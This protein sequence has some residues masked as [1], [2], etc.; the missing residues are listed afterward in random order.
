MNYGKKST[1]KKREKLTS[2]SS[3]MGNKAGVT[4]LRVLFLSFAAVC[5][6]IACMGIGAFRAI[7]DNS[8][9]ISDVNIMPIGNATFVYD[10]DGNMLQKLSAPT[11]NRMS[12][13]IDKIPLDMQHAIVAIEDE[14]FY[15]HNGIDV[16]GILR[17]FVNGVSRGFKFNEGASTLTQQLLKNNV[18]TNWTNEGKIERFIRKFQEQY[19]ALQLEASLTAEGMDTKSVILENYLN[20]INLSAGTYGVQAAAQRY[21]GKNSQDLTLSECAVLAAIP[22]NPYAFNPI[23]HPEKNAERRK[24]VLKNMLEQG[25]ITQEE[26]DEALAD[27]V[28]EQ[29]KETDSSQQTAT[30][31]SYFTDELTSQLIN[32]FQT[33]LGYTKVQAQNALYSGGLSIYTTQ[34]PDIQ[35]IMDEEYQNE[36]NFPSNTQLGLDWALTVTKADGTTQNYSK[37]MMR[38]YFRD[39]VDD[40]FDLLFETEEDARACVEQY[41]E[42]ILNDGDSIVAE[43][44]SFS[45]QPQSSMVII[46]Q[47]T[48]YVK[49]IVGGRGKKTASLTL[50]RATDTYRQPGSTFK[51][52]AVYGPAINDLSLTLADTYVDQGITYE[53]TNRPVKNAYSGYRGTMTIRDAIKVSCNTIAIQAFRDLT[54][55]VGYNYLKRM[56]FEEVTDHKVINGQ[57]FDD[58]REPTALGGITTGVSTLELTAAYAA[59]A[60]KG[61]YIKPVFYTKVLDH[62]G[63][64]LLDN[65]PET[66]QVFRDST[67]YLLTSAMESVVNEEGGT[68]GDL[69]LDNMP[70]AGKTGTTSATRDVWFAGFTP[71]YTCA[72]WAGSD[73]NELLVDECKSFHKTLWKKIM[74]RIHSELPSADFEIPSNVQQAT[75]CSESGLLAGLGCSTRTE[76]FESST[77]PTTRCTQHYVPP[78]PEPTPIPTPTEDPL[79]DPGT[80]TVPG[81]P[82]VPNGEAP[83][84]PAPPTDPGNGGDG[85]VTVVPPAGG[86]GTVTPPPSSP[87]GGAETPPTP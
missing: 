60:N 61:T 44:I 22:Q 31:Y 50:N 82:T 74:G 19:L 45:P 57:V 72:V 17:A 5:V 11:A 51:P 64:I 75:I 56:G 7:I 29:I 20:T 55:R 3:R 68:G 63:N 81:D 86:D 49:G 14:R 28:Y 9:D 77:I 87:E 30:P 83:D 12:V 40:Q 85:T 42:A 73:T 34:D 58:A 6:I 39:Q 23:N 26:H 2:S 4:I 71:Y 21:F 80:G 67:A 38:L 62:N 84:N 25:Y 78:T 15:E 43:R 32:D 18:F 54:P 37:E 65:E 47:H 27:N 1:Q 13:S 24:K 10:A 48:G 79:G 59:I 69:R 76:Y 16:R 35:S 70:V 52:L 8:P 66:E 46:D 53:D 41:K 36:E 33:E